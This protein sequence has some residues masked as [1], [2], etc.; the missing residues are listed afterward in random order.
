[1]NATRLLELVGMG[2]VSVG[3]GLMWLPVGLIVAGLF[4][5]AV[6]VGTWER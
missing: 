2:L 6:A 3:A 5:I 1:M 4:C